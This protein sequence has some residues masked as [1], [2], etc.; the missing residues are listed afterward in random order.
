MEN[1]VF[2]DLLIACADDCC[3]NRVKE[4][5]S[6]GIS[7]NQRT[8]AGCSPLMFAVMPNE[9]GDHNAPSAVMEMVITLID[10]GGNVKLR[11]KNQLSA[12]DYAKLLVD[13]DWK[14]S[15]GYSVAELWDDE[16][17]KT[18][19]DIIELLKTDL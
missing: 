10:L 18:I 12:C 2:N 17:K 7:V 16:D 19:L 8:D 3:V 11:D 9:C 1:Y 14:D 4:I 13:S 5:I 15:F 6:S